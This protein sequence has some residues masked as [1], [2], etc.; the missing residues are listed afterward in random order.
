VSLCLRISRHLCL[1]E[2]V[3]PSNAIALVRNFLLM[4][5]AVSS[6]I[7]IYQLISCWTKDCIAIHRHS[8]KLLFF[9][10]ISCVNGIKSPHMAIDLHDVAKGCIMYEIF[11]VNF[12]VISL[13]TVFLD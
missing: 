8:R 5:S 13:C 12:W 7:T 6:V 3:L 9:S 11:F 1:N 10:L 2:S 4:V